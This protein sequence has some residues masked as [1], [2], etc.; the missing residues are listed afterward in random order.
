MYLLNA[1]DSRGSKAFIRICL[2][3][4]LFVRSITQKNEWLQ[5]SNLVYET[6]LGYP[7]TDMVLILGQKVKG[8]CHRVT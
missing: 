5:V 2:C 6:A 7:T 3:V 8:R 1:D 4:C